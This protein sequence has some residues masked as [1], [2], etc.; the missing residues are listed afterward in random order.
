MGQGVID[1]AGIVGPLRQT[2]YN[3]WIMVADECERAETDPDGATLENGRF[4]NDI[5]VP[6]SA[7]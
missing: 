2:E 4:V 7:R 3:G 6:L 1:F 5:L